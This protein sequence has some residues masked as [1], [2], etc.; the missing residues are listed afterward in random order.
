MCSFDMKNKC[1]SHV[2][3][4][5]AFSRTCLSVVC[6][7]SKQMGVPHTDKQDRCGHSSPMC[8]S[9]DAILGRKGKMAWVVALLPS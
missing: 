3:C 9:H 5:V 2:A 4:A 6:L 1:Y 7:W 8:A